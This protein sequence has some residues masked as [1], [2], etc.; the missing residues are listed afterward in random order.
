MMLERVRIPAPPAP[1][2]A[3]A[4]SSVQNEFEIA[5]A[6]VPT[7]REEEMSSALKRERVE[8]E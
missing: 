5:Q 4:A 6:R 3:R 7:P 2:T 8:R 1:V